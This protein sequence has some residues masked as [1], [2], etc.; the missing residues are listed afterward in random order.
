MSNAFKQLLEF[1]PFQVDPEQRL[2]L[3]DRQSIPLSP[4]AFDL[5]LALLQ[6][7]GQVV[8]KDDLMRLLWPD[9]FVEE[10]NL[11]QHVFQLRK[12]LGERAQD[13]AYIVTIPGRGYRFV[14]PV[15]AL[16]VV[17]PAVTPADPAARGHEEIVV[18][19]HT[20]SRM[21]IE[22][23]TLPA[24]PSPAYVR[25][26]A[27]RRFHPAIVFVGLAALLAVAYVFRPA[28]P[29]PT[30][31]R[32]RQ[33]THLGTLVFN[34]KL[35]TDGPRIYFREWQGRNRVIRYVSPDGGEISTVPT[36]FPDMDLDD[37]S[38]NGSEFL[39]LQLADPRDSD[40]GQ[41]HPL[42]R[43]GTSSGS[44]RAVGEVRALDGRWSPDGNTIAY[45]GE[46]SLGLVNGDGGNARTLATLPGHPFYPQWSRDGLHLRFSLFD[47]HRRGLALWQTDLSGH[48]RPLFPDWPVS[49]RPR[50]GEWTPDGRY[51]FFT[52]IGDGTRN[53]WVVHEP[54]EWLRR[55]NPQPVRLTAG[56]LNFFY[57]TP[58]RDGKT[59]FATG[60]QERGQLLRYDGASH[61][62]V[63]YAQGASVDHVAF[64]RDGQWMAYVEY[65][66]GVLVRSKVD[67]SDRR[68]L[69]FPPMRAL[70]P[71]WS[72]DG[73]QVAFQATADLGVDR[74]IY[75]VSRD[76]GMPALATPPANDLQDYPSWSAKGD[77]L[78]FAAS[79]DSGVNLTLQSVDVKSRQ[80]TEFPRTA[81]LNWGALSPDGRHIAAITDS[82]QKL[83]LYDTA[84]H[85]TQTLAELGD[86]PTWST[87][88][89]YL[90]FSTLFFRKPDAGIYRY[91]VSTGRVEKIL[92]APDFLLAG[93]WGVWYGFTPKG[94]P[95]VVRDMGS[96][97]LYALDLDLP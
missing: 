10:S 24:R 58:S 91:E 12:A 76:G 88:G 34:T 52:A 9:T 83:V 13:H 56:P 59:I 78:V 85:A 19:S 96:T 14:Q 22:E 7:S 84:T 2:L 6:R 72:P 79:D 75:L 8:M 30:V 77:V 92:S 11:G 51:F 67:G 42:W 36:M 64:S 44:P 15:R 89:R 62:F 66:Q 48:A 54:G 69:T 27:R 31:V 43:V 38:P 46:S 47:E 1:G 65:P 60:V 16:P 94:E 61:Q 68:Q 37:I 71:Q 93:I 82:P 17:T 50:S 29:A 3:R 55:V 74:K 35:L 23:E 32:I 5:L 18:Q 21:V 97:D 25:P 49:S 39:V 40:A 26:V 4:K 73:T 80:V 70:H 33:L 81:G 53:I 87:D 41:P 86:Y 63:P 28:V 20:R 95:L 90:Y 57:P 45:A